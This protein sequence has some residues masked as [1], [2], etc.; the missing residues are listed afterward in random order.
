MKLKD[1][2]KLI[3]HLVEAG[4]GDLPVIYSADEKG[5]YYTDVQIAPE[6][7]DLEEL[8]YY[9]HG[10]GKGVCIKMR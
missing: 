1:Y 6:I 4:L 8:E 3:D 2:K 7:V 10:K 5:N 9:G